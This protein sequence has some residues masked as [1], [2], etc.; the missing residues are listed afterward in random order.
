MKQW[1]HSH[2][3]EDHLLHSVVLHEQNRRDQGS[4]ASNSILCYRDA[5]ST[6]MSVFSLKEI[7][8]PLLTMTQEA[9]IFDGWT[10]SCRSFPTLWF[11]YTMIQWSSI[12]IS[13]KNGDEICDPITSKLLPPRGTPSK[14]MLL[15]SLFFLVSVDRRTDTDREEGCAVAHIQE[16]S[17]L[18]KQLVPV[19]Y[20]K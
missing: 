20:L 5:Q 9:W 7:T 6:P 3:E 18:E 13:P 4:R 12:A 10:R 1:K 11:Y 2:Y 19:Q 14:A 15:R 8:F 16:F 17:T